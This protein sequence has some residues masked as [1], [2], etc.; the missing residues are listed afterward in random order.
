MCQIIL[1]P[2]LLSQMQPWWDLWHQDYEQQGAPFGGNPES[3]RNTSK[4]ELNII[5]SKG[6]T[7][8]RNPHL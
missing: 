1:L 8:L 3:K 4:E 6:M 5:Q 7:F 2:M